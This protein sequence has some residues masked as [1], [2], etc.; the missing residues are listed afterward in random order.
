LPSVRPEGKSRADISI[1]Y[2]VA[3]MKGALKSGIIVH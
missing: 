3:I 1:H 2:T